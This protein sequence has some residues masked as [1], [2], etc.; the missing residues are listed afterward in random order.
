MQCAL[1][2]WLSSTRCRACS[3]CRLTLT[4]LNIL[5]DWERPDVVKETASFQ[6]GVPGRVA[7]P[8]LDGPNRCAA[9]PVQLLICTSLPRPPCACAVLLCLFGMVCVT[10]VALS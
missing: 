7:A 6:R 9:D 5:F 3:A 1:M 2:P 10:H 8:Q 4:N